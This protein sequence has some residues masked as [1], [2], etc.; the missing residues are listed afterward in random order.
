MQKQWLEVSCTV[1]AEMVDPLAGFLIEKSQSGVSIDNLSVDTFTV[2]TITDTPIKTIKAYFPAD[3]S[4]E[5]IRSDITAF[6]SAEFPETEAVPLQILVIGE[7]DW[8]NNW[9]TYFKPARI[10]SSLVIKPTWES[11]DATPSDII[12]EIDPGQAFGTGTH[13]TTRLCLE[14]LEKIY[15]KLPPFENNEQATPQSVLDVGTGS[16]VLSIAAAKLGASRL[17]AVDIDPEAVIVAKDNLTLNGVTANV[18]VGTTMLQEIP[19][20]YHI[21]VANIIAEELVKLAHDLTARLAPKGF[22][23]LSGILVEREP[24][25]IEGFSTFPLSLADISHREEWSCLVYIRK[26]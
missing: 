5:G 18:T 8:A 14:A 1:P 13:A 6:I 12:I 26:G 20:S 22:L 16:G 11:F 3:S 24:F 7:E 15:R 21:V 2:E 9:K 17:C 19:G 23:V 10:G 4:P 25:V